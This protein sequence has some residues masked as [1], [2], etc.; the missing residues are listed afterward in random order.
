LKISAFF[1]QSVGLFSVSYDL[2]ANRNYFP[3]GITDSVG[4][5]PHITT[6]VC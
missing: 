5:L 2:P 1:P 3:D 6:G 4:M